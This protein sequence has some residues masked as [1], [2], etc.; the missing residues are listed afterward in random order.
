M[1]R[2]TGSKRMSLSETLLGI[3]GVRD[4]VK[5]SDTGIEGVLIDVPDEEPKNILI[6]FIRGGVLYEYEYNVDQSGH[7]VRKDRIDISQFAPDDLGNPDLPPI[8]YHY[9]ITT[10]GPVIYVCQ[11][12]KSLSV[13]VTD[14]PVDSDPSAPYILLNP[15]ASQ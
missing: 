2:K 15:P 3:K 8:E 6:K 14:S 11:G 7:P 13:R 12:F 10:C 4:K 1:S 9:I 5:L